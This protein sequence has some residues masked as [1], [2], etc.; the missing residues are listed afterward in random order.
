M[1]PE[2]RT[3]CRNIERE[4]YKLNGEVNELRADQ[5]RLRELRATAIS[6]INTN[7]REITRLQ[8][9]RLTACLPGTRSSKRHRSDDFFEG[10]EVYGC[11][12]KITRIDRQISKLQAGL[13]ELQD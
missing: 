10:I 2:Q 5:S 13:R 3:A 8:R 6:V 11:I 9:D 12:Q 7:K 4:G 1:T